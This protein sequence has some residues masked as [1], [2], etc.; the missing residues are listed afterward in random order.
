M[1]HCNLSGIPKR[2]HKTKPPEAG[3]IKDRGNDYVTAG[4]VTRYPCC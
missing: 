2:A 4:A 1:K 3:E